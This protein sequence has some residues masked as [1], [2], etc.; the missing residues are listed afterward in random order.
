LNRK[1]YFGICFGVLLL[2]S[3]VSVQMAYAEPTFSFKF[4]TFGTTNN[5]LKNPHDVD[6]SSDGRS[7]YVTDTDNH[8]IIVFDD[9]GDYDYKFGTFCNMTSIQNCNDDADEQTVMVMVNLTILLV[10]F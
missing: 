8:R 1:S 10:E 4:G 5:Q 3:I 7:I 9:D 2:I 6:V